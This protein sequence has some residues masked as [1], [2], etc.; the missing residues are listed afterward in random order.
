M[1]FNKGNDDGQCCLVNS[2]W[3]TWGNQPFFAQVTQYISFH[4]CVPS[5]NRDFL[6]GFLTSAD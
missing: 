2:Q 1:I 5:E 6:H 3:S 4:L